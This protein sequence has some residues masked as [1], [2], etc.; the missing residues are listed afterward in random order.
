MR[1]KENVFWMKMMVISGVIFRRK[2]IKKEKIIKYSK[3]KHMKL[4]I[5]VI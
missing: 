2:K 4:R 3:D 1:G 5:S